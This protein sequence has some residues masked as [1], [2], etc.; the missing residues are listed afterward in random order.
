[1]LICRYIYGNS[2]DNGEKRIL[3]DGVPDSGQYGV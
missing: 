3:E 1:M 2:K